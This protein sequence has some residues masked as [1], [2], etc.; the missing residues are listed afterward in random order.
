MA[1]YRLNTGNY[2][3]NTNLCIEPTDENPDVTGE[4]EPQYESFQSVFAAI[5]HAKER[6]NYKLSNYS[7]ITAYE[8]LCHKSSITLLMV[9]KEE[10]KQDQI[11]EIK[12]KYNELNTGRNIND[13]KLIVFYIY[14][15]STHYRAFINGKLYDPYDYYQVNDSEGFCQTF[16]YF[17]AIQDTDSFIQVS[18][19]KKLNIESFQNL[20]I[21]TQLCATKIFNILDNDPEI[22][23]KFKE[24]FDYIVDDTYPINETK[25]FDREHYGIKINTTCKQYFDD[26]RLINNDLNYVKD[27][28]I[29]LQFPGYYNKRLK[30]ALWFSYNLE[31]EEL[32]TIEGT[33][34]RSLDTK[35]DKKT[36]KRTRPSMGIGTIV[37]SGK[38]KTKKKKKKGIKLLKKKTKKKKGGAKKK[39]KRGIKTGG[40]PVKRKRDDENDETKCEGPKYNYRTNPRGVVNTSCNGQEDPFSREPIEHG[41]CWHNQCVDYTSLIDTLKGMYN[42]RNLNNIRDLES[43]FNRQPINVTLDQ[44][45]KPSGAIA[46][47]RLNERLIGP[48]PA[49]DPEFD[50][51]TDVD[52]EG[53]DEF[54]DDLEDE[55]RQSE[56]DDLL[57]DLL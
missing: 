26:F 3:T 57:D 56:I 11:K 43:P 5:M 4:F 46:D 52:D 28:I 32:A 45:V 24:E 20:A 34:K 27:Y 37:G 39:K 40:D 12:G 33:K 35:G 48:G 2:Y 47:T 54:I 55:E 9:K 25:P 17:L 44:I 13:D 1:S 42:T 7:D 6:E 53:P 30:D 41:I 8:L 19:T 38:R 51:W 18:K 10:K 50:F 22:M 14:Y 23:D 31:P 36:T 16:A 29:G 49:P 21:N 15:K